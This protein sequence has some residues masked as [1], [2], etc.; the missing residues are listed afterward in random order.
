MALSVEING[1]RYN[2]ALDMSCQRAIDNATGAFELSSSSQANNFL[3]VKRGDSI[4][5]FA[6]DNVVLTG[7]CE[8]TNPKY[9]YN[10]HSISVSGR[11][12]MGDFL[13]SSIPTLLEFEGIN[14]IES[15]TRQVL[16]DMNLSFVGVD[17]QV[18][19]I[20]PFLADDP[21]SAEVG[22]TGFSFINRLAA[23]R[24]LITTTDGLGNVIF[25]RAGTTQLPV[26][27]VYGQNILSAE[28]I[29][30]DTKRF[31]RYIAKSQLDPT[32]QAESTGYSS[33]SGQEGVSIDNDIR[34]SRITV[35][36][37]EESMDDRTCTQRA[38]LE[39]NLRRSNGYLYN[40][41]VQGHSITGSD[42]IWE[43]N[44]LVRVIDP[45]CG[46]DAILLIRAVKWSYSLNGG[47]ITELSLTYKDAYSVQA[48]IGRLDAQRNENSGG[49]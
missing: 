43:P 19:N 32:N 36:D 45:L 46:V 30:D 34:S 44:R 47:S 39:A 24:Q 33:L 14:T 22:E 20:S 12:V 49:F 6:D 10:S 48:E 4:R 16:D 15:I 41:S 7:F 3:P 18:D 25:I 1:T 26:K 38:V 31:Q 28:G 21:V 11:D 35:F 23:K 27:L 40:C 13:D 5:I 37:V 42:L 9:S 17:N 2:Q 29:F 8:K